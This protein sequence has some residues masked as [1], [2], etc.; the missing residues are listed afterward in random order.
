MHCHGRDGQRPTEFRI[1]KQSAITQSSRSIGWP[2]TCWERSHRNCR[3]VTSRAKVDIPRSLGIS[4]DYGML[5]R[6]VLDL[7][8]TPSTPCQMAVN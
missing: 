3:P 2:T 5:R 1:G 4:A 6:A 7:R 8:L